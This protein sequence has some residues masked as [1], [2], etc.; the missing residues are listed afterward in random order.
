[1]V[2]A[3]DILDVLLSFEDGEQQKVGMKFGCAD[4][5]CLWKK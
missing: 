2:T 1:M 5:C 3:E 4:F